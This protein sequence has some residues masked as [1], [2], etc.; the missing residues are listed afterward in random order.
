MRKLIVAAAIAALTVV[1][2]D[3]GKPA[4]APEVSENAPK[5]LSG[6]THNIQ[7]DLSG[8]YMPVTSVVV[9]KYRLDHLFIAQSGEFG[10]WEKGQTSETFGPVMFV[11]D[12]TS[13]PKVANELGGEGHTVT[14]RVLP[15]A[16]AVTDGAVR[17]L[18]TSPELGEVSFE[19]TLDA[20]ALAT[21]RRNL[22]AS[23]TPVLTGMLWVGGKPFETQQFG[24]WVGD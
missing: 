12:D 17:F 5:A 1:A 24:W 23:E 11:F 18:G 9:G 13:S 4:E 2:C 20:G 19:G 7:S 21:A 15:T 8:F 22:G 3:Q 16:Y 14:L 10:N 6:F